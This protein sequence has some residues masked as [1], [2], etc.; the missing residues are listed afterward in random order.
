MHTRREQRTDF[1]YYYLVFV[2]ALAMQILVP[3]QML[4]LD[5]TNVRIGV[6]DMKMEPLKVEIAKVQCNQAKAKQD[7]QDAD[8]SVIGQ[9]TILDQPGQ[10]KSSVKGR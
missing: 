3:Q 4:G 6:S 9:A 1:L 7:Y 10:K 8:A 2:N 5:V